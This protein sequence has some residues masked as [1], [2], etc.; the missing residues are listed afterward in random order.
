MYISFDEANKDKRKAELDMCY[1][2]GIAGERV[3][4]SI[5]DAR[6]RCHKN[7]GAL[8]QTL[9]IFMD[10]PKR[11]M[12]HG[13]IAERLKNERK[14]LEHYTN[15]LNNHKRGRETQRR[16]TNGFSFA[17]LACEMAIIDERTNGKT[18][19]TPKQDVSN[20][21]KTVAKESVPEPKVSSAQRRRFFMKLRENREARHVRENA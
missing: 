6:L 15:C 10:E 20:D 5:L 18:T 9:V 21:K 13:R 4:Q 7:V 11:R 2:Y 8:E 17:H 3:P 1:R 14:W 12:L 16:S 19:D